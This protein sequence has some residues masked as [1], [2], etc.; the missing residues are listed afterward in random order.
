MGGEEQRGARDA[1]RASSHPL[2]LVF[3]SKK[4]D[5]KDKVWGFVNKNVCLCVCVFCRCSK[6]SHL[7]V[8]TK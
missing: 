2:K 1:L 8:V 4:F 7:E 5:E 6:T 3:V